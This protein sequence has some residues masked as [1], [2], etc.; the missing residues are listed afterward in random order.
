MNETTR[1]KINIDFIII[2]LLCLILSFF[3]SYYLRHH[4]ILFFSPELYI[5]MLLIIIATQLITVLAINP[6]KDVIKRNR[7]DEL[8]ATFLLDIILSVASIVYLFIVKNS[9]EYS[10]ITLFLTY[11][12]YF[13]SSYLTRLLWKRHIRKKIKS[14]INSG[15]KPLLVICKSVDVKNIV[16]TI[17]KN[18]YDYY[19]IRG[20][21][22]VDNDAVGEKIGGCSVVTNVKDV[23][24]YV[25]TNWI[26]DILIATDYR[27][28]PSDVI[29]GLKV[30][31]IPIHI[32]LDDISVF[33]DKKQSIGV[34]GGY[35]VITA[36]V[37][38]TNL[39]QSAIKRII[40]ILGGLVGCLLTIILTIIIGPIIYI[41][42]PGNIFY[43]SKR[44]GKNG[45][46]FN[47]YKFR[48]MVINADEL[49]SKYLKDNRI[50]SGMMFKLDNDPRIIP[51][52]GQFIRKTSLDEFPQFFNVLKGEMSIVGTRPP[53]LDE[54]NKY[55][56]SYR[57][58]LS[59]KP[60]ITGL[61]QVSGRSNIT[62]FDEVVKLDSYYI[63]NRSFWLDL[64]II[65]K[66]VGM[67]FK[68][69][70]DREAL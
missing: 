26:D 60:G 68:R 23:L 69:K 52:I 38:E 7:Y 14:A 18:N 8:K 55:S 37:N 36:R 27:K 5:N 53:T 50:K 13:F 33:E 66:T 12:I 51:G 1:K 17:S 46:V 70:N 28:L 63:N 57:F 4:N 39:L 2:D 16:N 59:I 3:L 30:T 43:V 67:I 44:V 29:D 21:C 9:N 34:L 54:W 48:S 20:L 42:S 47:F 58:R 35:N 31:G 22:L 61:W 32:I 45:K 40:D 49:K 64:S 11:V 62:D 41:K 24:N 25:S 56:P 10:R 15:N 19:Y 6:F 65:F